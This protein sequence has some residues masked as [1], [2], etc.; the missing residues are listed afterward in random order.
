MARS[1]QAF[2]AL[3]AG[4]FRRCRACLVADRRRLALIALDLRALHALDRVVRHGVLIGR[5]SNSEDSAESLRRTAAWGELAGSR[6]L[7]QAR[8][9]ARV[10]SR[11]SSG[12][13]IPTKVM[14]SLRSFRYARRV[15]GLSMFA[16]HSVSGGTSE[17]AENSAPVRA[18]RGRVGRLGVSCLER[19]TWQRSTIAGR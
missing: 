11:S 17:S 1:R 19:A 2:K 9:W 10:I 8:T 12:V 7:R 3:P 14:N 18:R 4:S 15:F 13:R 5:N 6:S 16:N